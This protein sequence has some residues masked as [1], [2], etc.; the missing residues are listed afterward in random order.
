MNSRCMPITK[1]TGGI[2][3]RI[4]VAMMTGQSAMSSQLG[5]IWRM[6]TTMVFID[7]SVVI[8]SGQRYW[9]QP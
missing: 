4:D 1:I 2:M 5:N 3:A 8:S 7:G 6:P 9:F